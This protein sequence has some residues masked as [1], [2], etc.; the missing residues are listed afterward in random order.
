M[1]STKND[2]SQG[3]IPG[4]I[5]R[6][7]LPLMLGQF[8]N[9][10]Y[11][12]VDRMYIGRIPGAD[13][14]ALTGVGVSFPII[15]VV[16]AFAFLIGTGGPPLCSIARGRQEED[17][18]EAVMGNSFALLLLAGLML[19]GVGLLVKEPLLYA[20]GASDVTFPYANEYISIYLL[21]SVFVMISMGMNGFINCQGFARVGMLTVLIGAVI[22][23]VL[24]PVFIFLFHMGVRGAAIATVISQ[25]VSALWIV[26]FLTGK[27]TLLR[28]RFSCMKLRCSYVK[29]IL[30]LGLS[31]FIMQATNCMVQIVCNVTLQKYGG[32]VYV[33]VMTIINS[34]R[35]VLSVPVNGFAQGAQPIIGYNYGAGQYGRVKQGIKFMSVIC[36]GYTTVVWILTMLIPG[37]FIALFNGNEELMRVGVHAMRIYFFGFCFMSLQ[38]SGQTVFTGLG[39]AK[40]AIF[41]SLLRKAVIV[42][43]LTLILPRAAGL[44]VNGVFLAEPISNFIGGTACFAAM[45]CIMWP[46]LTK[47]E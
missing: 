31:G 26:R 42:V 12:I 14:A 37:A 47:K 16:M 22:N 35:E 7:S 27:K 28:L 8:I 39:K 24:D 17:K 11:N 6:L 44:G 30:A 3:S 9:V 23:I 4:N 38:F 20:L 18:A 10:L 33:G 19:I 46:A 1:H 29:D 34:V 25:G 15:T 41:F 40:Q 45:L 21:G 5:L 43:P 2:F 13:A 32:D 36:I